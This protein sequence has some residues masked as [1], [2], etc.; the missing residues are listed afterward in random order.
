MLFHGVTVTVSAFSDFKKRDQFDVIK[1]MVG[2]VK[3][4]WDEFIVKEDLC[5]LLNIVAINHVDQVIRGTREILMDSSSLSSIM[6][7]VVGCVVGYE[8]TRFA[9]TIITARYFW[10]RRR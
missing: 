7:G 1:G 10:W 3:M 9:S 6:K 4:D 5:L 8:F 2:E